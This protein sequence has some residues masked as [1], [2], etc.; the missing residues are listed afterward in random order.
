M[1]STRGIQVSEN[2][3]T[4]SKTFQHMA[5]RRQFIRISAMGA[6]AVMAGAAGFRL[7]GSELTDGQKATAALTGRTPTYCE[8]CFW[9]CAGWVWKDDSGN[10][11]KI[12]G[13]NDDQ[14]CSG[15]F[16]PRGTGGPGMYYDEDRLKV[17][18]DKS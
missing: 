15:R 14:H 1:F 12:T 16:C 2:I 3:T 8:I 9:K 17:P 13:N 10:I 18:S 11:K 4:H 6:G 5:T 7:L